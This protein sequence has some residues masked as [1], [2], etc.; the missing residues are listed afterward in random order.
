MKTM[1]DELNRST[2]NV[3]QDKIDEI[4]QDYTHS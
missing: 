2:T 1:Y 4:Y 3:D